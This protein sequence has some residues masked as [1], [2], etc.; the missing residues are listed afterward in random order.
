[1]DTRGREGDDISCE[2]RLALLFLLLDGE[3]RVTIRLIAACQRQRSKPLTRRLERVETGWPRE[4][5]AA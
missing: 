5:G 4:K 1:M 3:G 2:G